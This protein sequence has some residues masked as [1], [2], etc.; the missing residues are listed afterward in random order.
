MARSDPSHSLILENG[1]CN[2]SFGSCVGVL[3][4]E[5]ELLKV[6][7]VFEGDGRKQILASLSFF[8]MNSVSNSS[9]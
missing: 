4:E 3:E 7:N 6:R 1:N 5:A 8:E 9:R 2:G